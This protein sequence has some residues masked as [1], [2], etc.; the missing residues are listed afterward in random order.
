MLNWV[1]HEK[2]FYNLGVWFFLLE[3]GLLLF[4]CCIWYPTQL[5]DRV[6][7]GSWYHRSMAVGTGRT[8]VDVDIMY[9][10]FRGLGPGLGFV[11]R[12]MWCWADRGKSHVSSNLDLYLL[13]DIFNVVHLGRQFGIYTA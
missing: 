4:R 5:L 13:M 8:A 7:N 12:A 3:I 10:S 1:E 9:G 2:S 6:Q 11:C